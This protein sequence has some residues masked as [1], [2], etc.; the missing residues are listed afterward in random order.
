MVSLDLLSVAFVLGGGKVLFGVYPLQVA[1][2]L[3]AELHLG[4]ALVDEA[5]VLFGR[6]GAASGHFGGAG[7]VEA[8]DEEVD[9]LLLLVR[10]VGEH[11]IEEIAE[12]EVP[13]GLEV[14]VVL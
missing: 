11:L 5:L 10:G 7:G 14:D 12:G 1:V 13:L 4:D 9:E 3:D 2:E 6:E 8:V